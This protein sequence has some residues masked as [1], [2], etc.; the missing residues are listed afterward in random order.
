MTIPRGPGARRSPIWPTSS[1]A[2]WG[3]LRSG[4]L[5]SGCAEMVDWWIA[6]QER[7]S[8]I[9]ATVCIVNERRGRIISHPR[10]TTLNASGQRE[11]E[12]TVH[13]P[14]RLN[15]GNSRDHLGPPRPGAPTGSAAAS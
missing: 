4:F 15:D 11:A 3:G 1:A 6:V 14:R 13:R 10:E 9:A 7:T 12:Q 8:A 5:G 2:T